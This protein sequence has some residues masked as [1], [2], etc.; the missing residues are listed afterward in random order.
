MS[1]YLAS[2]PIPTTPKTQTR[3]IGSAK[4]STRT[5]SISNMPTP[6]W[7]LGSEPVRDRLRHRRSREVSNY[8]ERAFAAFV[9]YTKARLL[10]SAGDRAQAEAALRIAIDV[11]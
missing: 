4:S 6:S 10:L 5:S 3:S 2:W 7:L 9:Q 8:G 1:D 11:A